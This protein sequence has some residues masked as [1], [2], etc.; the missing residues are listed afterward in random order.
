MDNNSIIDKKTFEVCTHAED[1]PQV[2]ICDKPIAPVIALLNKKGYKTFAS[3]SGHY[4]IEFHEYLDEDISKLKEYQSDEKIIIKKIKNNTFDYWQEI[5]GT[6]LY[7]LFDDKYEFD[8]LP[9][10]FELTINDGRDYLRTCIECII[11]FYDENNQHRKMASV[12][13]EIDNKCE[14]LRQWVNKL[15]ENKNCKTKLS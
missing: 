4:R 8:N 14:I 12:L 11:N 15:P 2:F 7:I 1:H 5:D 3:C 9:E 6:L 13:K 10:D